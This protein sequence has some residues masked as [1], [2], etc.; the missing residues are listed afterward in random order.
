MLSELGS[1]TPSVDWYSAPYAPLSK[2]VPMPIDQEPMTAS[3]A[4]APEL[5]NCPVKVA[6][7]S[8]E[9]EPAELLIDDLGLRTRERPQNRSFPAVLK[10]LCVMS[11]SSI[12]VTSL[13]S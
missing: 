8:G 9:N 7:T 12:F 13:P 10:S 5:R 2:S 11:G 3:P 4:S 6:S 1:V